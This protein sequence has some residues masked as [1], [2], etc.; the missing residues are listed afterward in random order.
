MGL[1]QQREARDD[2]G[3]LTQFALISR[4]TESRCLSQWLIS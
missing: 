3:D 4:T 1:P 2:E